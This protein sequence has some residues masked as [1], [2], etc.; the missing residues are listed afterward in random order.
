MIL[1]RYSLIPNKLRYQ[2]IVIRRFA[3][4]LKYVMCDPLFKMASD[5]YIEAF[6]KYLLYR[7]AKGYFS[8]LN[9]F[10]YLCEIEVQPVNGG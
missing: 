2:N 9:L 6:L 8:G 7:I 5:R 3:H 10:K 4:E 1:T